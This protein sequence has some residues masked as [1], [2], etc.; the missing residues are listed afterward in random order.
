MQPLY[1]RAD[2][3]GRARA[4]LER[5]ARGAGRLLLF[6]GEPGIGKSR[7]SEQVAAD[8]LERGWQVAWG[9]CWEAGGAP[10]YWPW[11]QVFRSL[12]MEADP[13]A[14]AGAG[15]ALGAAEVRFAAFDR[16]VR[17]LKQSAERRPLLLVLDDLH[18]ADAPSLLLLL[19]LARELSRAPIVVI[20]AYRDAELRLT[21]EIAGHLAKVAR[22]AEVIPL[23]RLSPEDVAAW[24]VETGPP[25]AQPTESPASEARAASLYRLTEGHPLLVVEALRL[26]APGGGAGAWP[27]EP[28][29]VLDER[30]AMLTHE[31]Q[32][33]LQVAA[34]LGRE[35][36]TGEVAATG[37]WS[38]DHVAAALRGALGASII[39]P[40]AVLEGFRFSH[41]LLRDRL[42]RALSPSRRAQLHVRAGVQLAQAGDAQAAAHHLF[43]GQGLEGKGLAGKSAVPPEYV[44]QVALAAA[45]AAL[46]RLAFEDAVS[47]GRR[48]LGLPAALSEQ[49]L[50]DRL[51][52]QLQRV[53][54]EALIRLGETLEG[55]QLAALAAE[56]AER[57][58]APE[59][60]ARAALAYGTELAS[61]TLDERMI[62][63]LRQALE[64]LGE[65]DSPLRARVLARLA[66]ALT[67]P[68]SYADAP[69]PIRLMH[70]AT[71]LARRVG[72]RQTLL[73]VLQFGS[74][75]SMLVPDQERLACMLET[76]ELARALGQRWTLL[77]T[78]PA[79]VT[80]LIV[81]GER[82][83]AEAELPGYDRL[84]EEFPQPLHRIRRGM[85][86]ALLFLLDGDLEAAERVSAE[87]HALVLRSGPGPGRALWLTHRFCFAQLL[88]KPD[89][90]AAEATAMIELFGS[91]LGSAPFVTWVLAGLGR[92]EEAIERLR[93]L[94][95]APQEPISAYLMDLM[96]AAEA[97]V[98]LMEV[99]NCRILYPRLLRAA[100]RMFWNL[101]PGAI[102]GPTAR[103]LG[104]LARVT[105]QSAE[106]LRHYDEAIAF[107][108]RLRAP[109]LVARCRQARAAVP[110]PP[111]TRPPS[112]HTP[113]TPARPLL[114]L[115]PLAPRPLGPQLGALSLRREGD[116]WTLASTTGALVRLRHSKGMSYL[117]ALLEQPG[118]QL[119]VVE[120]A[121]IDH[122]TGDAGAVLDPRAKAAYR[123]RLDEL[124]AELAE[125]ESFGDSARAERSAR[126]IEAITEQ[127]A[128][129]VGLGGRD[130]RAAS[131]VERARVNVQ[132]RLK[133]VLDRVSAADPALGRYLRAA[134]ETGT[135]CTYQPL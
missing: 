34:V 56:L 112:T 59:L 25:E 129:A 11:R 42:Y 124:R 53:L 38:A 26:R 50:S 78:L 67:P 114:T 20:G 135:Y 79:F 121:G 45:E 22:E 128:G 30:L 118:R 16:A 87:L 98:Q 115:D 92:R 82:E 60:L 40:D 132:R 52:S 94:P 39:V 93:A 95:P 14:E 21:P 55:K 9:R 64:R 63:L 109:L 44:A 117:Q 85:I 127:L 54:A 58:G 47:L 18:A 134:L 120:L 68:R 125:A 27:A 113:A 7:L 66:A 61:G 13:F 89:L 5:A 126:E 8:A 31:A 17:R 57:A 119:H 35:F 19:L 91:G 84:L 2:V 37:E 10:A 108:E 106:A 81:R 90:I 48:A 65:Q 70:T 12:E 49:P 97:A 133:D 23:S 1:G 116:F 105:G 43:E 28:G 46:S 104:D 101:G 76:L 75:V 51:Q 24:L 107:C 100:D 33:V 41:V 69:E 88:G 73:Y 110:L 72:D 32:A 6:T 15:L 62:A 86:G 36:S 71:A 102:F 77:L 122:P 130:R 131:E 111:P 29:A 103:L 3:L 74:T 4:G 123:A 99:E 83:R 96:G 80:A